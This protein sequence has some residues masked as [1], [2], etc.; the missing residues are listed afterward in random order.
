M[1]HE[2][3][4]SSTQINIRSRTRL[5]LVLGNWPEE[6]ICV[7]QGIHAGKETLVI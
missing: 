7:Y 5:N 2:G 1:K 3:S 6:Y 4:V